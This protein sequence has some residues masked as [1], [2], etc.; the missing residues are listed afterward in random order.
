MIT[1]LYALTIDLIEDKTTFFNSNYNCCQL[2]DTTFNL[3]E[4][5]LYIGNIEGWD[6]TAKN[7]ESFGL[8]NKA[9]NVDLTDKAIYRHPHL[10]L[11]RQKVDLLKDKFNMKVIRNPDK[12][13]YHILS[14]KTIKSLLGSS[15][16]SHYT[17]TEAYKFFVE[18]KKQNIMSEDA[19]IRVREILNIL[20]KDARVSLERPYH[21]QSD[22]PSNHAE[23]IKTTQYISD[24]LGLLN[25]NRVDKGRDVIID[26][27]VKIKTFNDLYNSVVPKIFDTDVSNIIDIDLAVLETN[28]LDDITKMVHS[29]NI[30]D[31]TLAL[32]MLSNCNINKSFDVVSNIFYWEYDWIKDTKNWNTINVRSFRS[33]M[34]DFEGNASNGNI[35]S[36]NNYIK[37]LIACDKLTKF[38]VDYTRQKLYTNILGGIVGKT[39][40]VFSV[41][42]ESLEL[43]K[44]F[45]NNI[46]NEVN[47]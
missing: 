20:P 23:F 45:M 38:A 29:T 1:K 30:E 47:D 27:Q 3:K 26:D 46:L 14:I 17:Y 33:R 11:P 28:Q 21:N 15:W 42:L 19:L 2:L 43:K 24:Q 4:I 10:D 8:V 18:L 39:A 9:T 6:L 36:Y 40:D 22:L 13:D 7:I 32:E 37:Q 16:T 12:A 35:Y 44:D 31:R 41:S 34:K 5:G 25:E